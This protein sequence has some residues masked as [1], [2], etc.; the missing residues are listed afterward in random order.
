MTE[1]ELQKIGS[2]IAAA[3]TGR[4]FGKIF[5]LGAAALAIDLFPHEGRYL[6]AD[7]GRGN[8]AVFLI[9]RRLKDL[10]RS[11]THPSPFVIDL[12]KRCFGMELTNVSIIPERLAIELGLKDKEGSMSLI[13]Q[14]GSRPNI[15]ALDAG[16]TIVAAGHVSDREGHRVGDLYGPTAAKVTVDSSPEIQGPGSLSDS[17][18]AE[19]RAREQEYRFDALAV[20]AKRKLISEIRKKVKLLDNLEADLAKH[21]DADEWKRLGDLLLANLGN[22]RREDGKMIVIDYFDEK[23]PEVG[24]RVE[25]DAS[26]TEMAEIFFSRYAKARNGAAAIAYRQA[27]VNKELETLRSKLTNLETAILSR[28]HEALTE[29]LPKPAR[30]PVHPGKKKVTVE[31]KGARRF[32]SSDG[33]EILVGKKAV[34]NDHLTFRVARSHDLWLHAEDYPGSHVIVRNPGRK[35]IP[36]RTLIEAA[37]LAAFYSDARGLPKASVRYTLRKFVNKPRRAAPGLV[38]IASFRS[39]L[40]EPGVGDLSPAS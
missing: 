10:E 26:P 5:P 3:M 6:Y 32:I 30:V 14:V 1:N 35:E 34:D 17:M 33:F 22:I 27:T 12:A 16:R 19:A 25:N 40:V 31:F 23:M 38:S 20:A 18:D 21:G 13:L 39:I 36:Q 4:H 11:S 7:F 8:A 15:F 28:D 9:R 2:E 29:Y 24:V 37:Q